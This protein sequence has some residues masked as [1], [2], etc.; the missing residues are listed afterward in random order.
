MEKETL[1]NLLR[2]KYLR[3][4]WKVIVDAMFPGRDFFAYDELVDFTKD[5]Q[6]ELTESIIRFGNIELDDGA[7]IALYEVKLKNDNQSVRI[8]KNRVGLRN[9]I[10]AEVIP[11]IVDGA[12]IC[13]FQ[14]GIP[15]WRFSFFSKSVFWDEEG[16][17]VKKETHPKRYTYVLGPPETGE[18]CVT[19]RDRFFLLAERQ[20]R[21]IKDV[22]EAFSVE[23]VSKEFFVSYKKHYQRFVDELIGSTA[24]IWA[25]NK[26][27]KTVRDFVK[28]ML[29]RI[30]FL[31]YL[32]KKGWLDVPEDKNFGEG[33]KS[34]IKELFG[35]YDNAAFYSTCLIP[36]FFDTLNH[37][38]NGHYSVTGNKFPYLNGGLFER[39]EL[40]KKGKTDNLTFKPELFKD[41]FEFFA[42]YNFTID[43]STPD[44][45]DIGIDP[46]MLG[47]IF[48]NLLEENHEK[49]AYYTPKMIVQY[50]CQ[51]TLIQYLKLHLG[52][53]SEIEEFIRY[54]KIGDLHDKNNFI[55]NQAPKIE[56]LL[57]D[58]IICDPAIGSGAFPMGL[59]QEIFHAK[60]ALNWT[61]ADKAALK[62]RII[63]N[64]IYGVDL[65]RGAVDI[66]RLRF[67]LSIIVD[68]EVE[69]GEKPEALPNFDYKIMQ[70]NSL[71]E[72]FKGISLKYEEQPAKPEFQRNLFGEIIN[73]QMNIFQTI[74][75]DLVK[76]EKDLYDPANNHRK[77]EIRNSIDE[78]VAKTVENSIAKEVQKKEKLLK[79]F[80]V[81]L[82]AHPTTQQ[83]KKRTQLL[84]DILD[85]KGSQHE[86]KQFLKKDE[87]PYFLWHLFFKDAFDQ[88]GFD[89]LIGN[90]PYVRQ[91]LITAIKPFLQKEYEV[92][93][94]V[95]DLY[96]YFFELG[97]KILKADKGVFS[98]ICSKKY[99]RAQYGDNLRKY[100]LKNTKL[101]GYIDFDEVKVFGATVDTS[102]IL[103]QTTKLNTDKYSFPYCNVGN[104]LKLNS[105]LI[106]Y[107]NKNGATYSSVLLSTVGWNFLPKSQQ[108]LM[109]LIEKIGKRFQDWDFN[110]YRGVLTG[111]N[112]AFYISESQ[113]DALIL[114]DPNN[115]LIIKP[116]LRGRDIGRYQTSFNKIYMIFTRRGIDIDMYPAVKEYL[117]QFKEKLEPRPVDWKGD[118]EGRKPGPY[119]WY[120]IQDNISYY[121]EFEK[122]KIFWLVLSD[123]AKFAFEERNYYTNNAAFIIT[124]EN[125][126]YLTALLNS[127]VSEWYYDKVTNSSGQGTNKWE[128]VYIEQI[129]IP[130]IPKSEMQP[131]EI[132]VDYIT[133]IKKQE[134]I[135]SPYTPN[136]HM[137]TNFEELIDACVY[138]LYFKEH[139][140]EKKIDVLQYVTPLLQPIDHFNEETEKQKIDVLINRVYDQ[141]K[142]TNSPIRQR[143]LQFPVKSPDIINIIQNG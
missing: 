139:M 95:S 115:S 20:K 3:K 138:E 67:W 58:V 43:E 30:V 103:F 140:E 22:L 98:F 53:H 69:P 75:Q 72:S 111:F 105:P 134:Q 12:L 92:Y 5:A 64:S 34:F 121:E 133:Y 122:P 94:S 77:E 106:D 90:P 102:I 101:S 124:G 141:Y 11:G 23:K 104:D 57:D 143:M 38:K 16:K 130:E 118:W 91:E 81:N 114:K 32:Q 88:G 116:L 99:T 37:P 63:Q 14:E 131:F 85:L 9:L 4:N 73:P 61:I 132:I 31:H 79:E 65:D 47:H 27:E 80:V 19:P 51:E 2:Q 49:G 18:T 25:F 39:D 82:S 40:E 112:E 29:G 68:E 126:K 52:D 35:K 44:D 10:T 46:E 110:C 76:L 135:I 62:R 129:P 120:E 127:K 7:L 109:E 86:I 93:N 128:K 42:Q 96:T 123:K 17:Q 54:N 74:Q 45:L 97:H 1:H 55:R 36:L 21:T 48:E 113:K 56:K 100:L 50:M 107:L 108:H 78:L 26:E 117:L 142:A 41:L 137:A 70:G 13:Y 125:L 71:F 136:S 60:L 87:K 89:I 66:A 83:Q 84:Q 33:P 119:K 6:Y 24:F 8:A 28:K 59:L 15:E